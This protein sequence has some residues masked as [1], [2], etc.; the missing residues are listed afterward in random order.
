MNNHRNP[1]ILKE[2]YFTFNHSL[3]QQM[4]GVATGTP[5]APTFANFFM[6]KIEECFFLTQWQLSLLYKCYIDNI[7]SFGHMGW[8][9]FNDFIT[10][11]TQKHSPTHP[12]PK[13]Y[14][15]FLNL[16]IYA[17]L[18]RDTLR[19]RLYT[20]RTNSHQYGHASGSHQK[21]HHLH[22]SFLPPQ[23]LFKPA[24]AKQKLT[25][26]G[27]E[28]TPTALG[29]HLHRLSTKLVICN[30][31]TDWPKQHSKV[32]CILSNHA[33]NPQTSKTL[34]AHTVQLL[35]Q[36]QRK[37]H[38]CHSYLPETTNHRMHITEPDICDPM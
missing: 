32:N 17:D 31:N 20:K 12:L 7:S 30:K 15:N 34:W 1:L 35:W 11:V 29:P 4:S 9:P 38:L 22:Q 28:A 33:K 21:V 16:T 36:T 26:T 10:N 18:D 25:T 6:S 27:T 2:N 14:W 24:E 19:Y 37:H 8:T 13:T 5:I 3:Y 23:K